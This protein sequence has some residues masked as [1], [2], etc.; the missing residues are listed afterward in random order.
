M[1]G[2]IAERRGQTQTALKSFKRAIALRPQEVEY[3]NRYANLLRRTGQTKQT[4]ETAEQAVELEQNRRRLFNLAIELR[5]RD[6]TLQECRWIAS[7]CVA[8]GMSVQAQAWQRVADHISS[9]GSAQ[10]DSRGWTDD[11]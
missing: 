9:S 6:P 1:Q 7:Q 4:Q 2:T 8:F 11:R 10:L 5:S 3:Y